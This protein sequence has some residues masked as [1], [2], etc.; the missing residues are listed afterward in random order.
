MQVILAKSSNTP[1][2]LDATDLKFCLTDRRSV[3]AFATIFLRFRSYRLRNCAIFF[4][5]LISNAFHVVNLQI[6]TPNNCFN[7]GSS[8]SFLT[9]NIRKIFSHLFHHETS[10]FVNK[11]KR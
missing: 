3:D 6:Y 7:D 9:M 2:N 1:S 5:G 4:V 10:V 8:M 11:R